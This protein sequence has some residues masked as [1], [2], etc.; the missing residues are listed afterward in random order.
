MMEWLLKVWVLI[1]IEAQIQGS[2]STVQY[3]IS[4]WTV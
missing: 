1:R 3:F 4:S 2:S